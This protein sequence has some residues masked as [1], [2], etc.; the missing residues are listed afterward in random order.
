MQIKESLSDEERSNLLDSLSKETAETLL[1]SVQMIDLLTYLD[2]N[3]IKD[4]ARWVRRKTE[5]I[6]KSENS[7]TIFKSLLNTISNHAHEVK[8]GPYKIEFLGWSYLMGQAAR[9]EQFDVF[10]GQIEDEWHRGDFVYGWAVKNGKDDPEATF[11]MLVDFIKDGGK[12]ARQDQSL[13]D[14]VESFP[15]G[16]ELDFEKLEASL[17]PPSSAPESR[18]FENARRALLM[19]WA[20]S[21]PA[22]AVNHIIGNPE[23][24]SP[25]VVNYIVGE[26][27]NANRLG[28]DGIEWVNQFPPGPYYDQAAAA[29]V[30]RLERFHPE[31]A[32]Q[33]AA[34]IGNAELRERQFEYM[35]GRAALRARK[36]GNE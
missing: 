8:E 30:R 7:D 33:W 2:K 6:F 16:A 21:E 26:A 23:R 1:T 4:G 12:G 17:P 36:E 31:E 10:L 34:S 9:P 15:A 29:V 24:I 14:L 13:E 22:E 11:S 27:I 3:K 19:E 25:V 20:N 32:R 5:D 28:F 18:S 35:R